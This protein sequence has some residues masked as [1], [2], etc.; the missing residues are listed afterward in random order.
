MQKHCK[1]GQSMNLRLR[2]VIYQ[3][4]V[5]I[6]NVPIYSCETCTRSEVVPHVKPEL[7]GLIGK[8]GSKP[9]KQQIMFHEVSEVAYLLL[10]VT[11][12]EHMNDSM[13]KIVEER[14]NEL[15]DVLLLAQS[16]GDVPWTEEIRKRLAQITQHTMST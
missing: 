1:C 11:E 8:L 10:K 7:T 13:E 4:K 9:D 3:N 15:L 16:L 2:T 5:D 14:I 12:R 6:E